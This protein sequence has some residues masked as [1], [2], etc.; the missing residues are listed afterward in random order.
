MTLQPCALL[1]IHS[2]RT[3][4]TSLCILLLASLTLKMVPTL[5][6]RAGTSTVKNKNGPNYVQ[7]DHISGW[8][9]TG[10]NDTS[11]EKL[12]E[13]EVP[14]VRSSKCVK[15][16]AEADAEDADESLIV[17]AGGA[18]KGPCKVFLT[19]FWKGD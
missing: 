12:Q 11:T 10:V 1:K 14:I 2:Q 3:G 15:K 17:C 13:T 9:E 6:A 7:S 4:W 18:G 5:L 8:G 16:M 19:I